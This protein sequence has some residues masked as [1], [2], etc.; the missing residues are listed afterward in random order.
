MRFSDTF[1]L[2]GGGRRVK[3]VHSGQPSAVSR[4]RSAKGASVSGSGTGAPPGWRASTS[5][6][7]RIPGAPA[8]SNVSSG[9]EAG[10][11]G[12]GAGFSG[13]DGFVSEG[14]QVVSFCLG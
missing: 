5:R 6:S 1:N 11:P 7:S 3:G 9:A 12:A 14:V 8:R 10:G 13:G 2:K 4:Q